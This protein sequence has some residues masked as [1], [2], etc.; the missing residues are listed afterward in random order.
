MMKEDFPCEFN[1]IIRNFA[2]RYVLPEHHF[3]LGRVKAAPYKDVTLWGS[4][5]KM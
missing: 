5:T 2:E 4:R 1:A 3:T